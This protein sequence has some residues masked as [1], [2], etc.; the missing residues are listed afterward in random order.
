MLGMLGVGEFPF[1]FRQSLYPDDKEELHKLIPGDGT[2]EVFIAA[3]D[4]VVPVEKGKKYRRN[5]H[6]IC[7]EESD[8]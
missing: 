2:V 1:H 7:S 3:V 6:T 5:T 4:Q 8:G